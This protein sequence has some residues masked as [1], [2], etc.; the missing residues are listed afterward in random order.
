M[1]VILPRITDTD[2]DSDTFGPPGV[3]NG[4][5]Q[6]LLIITWKYPYQVS[7]YPRTGC[8][9]GSAATPDKHKTAEVIDRWALYCVDDPREGRS[10]CCRTPIL[11]EKKRLLNKQ[12]LIK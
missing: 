5:T 9:Q 1:W 10:W 6:Y 8:E 4:L 7:P 11:G 3:Q 2:I 12:Q